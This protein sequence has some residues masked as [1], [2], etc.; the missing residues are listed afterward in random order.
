MADPWLHIIEDSESEKKWQFS[1]RR[2][3]RESAKE[4]VL[5]GFYVHVTKSVVP[6]PGEMKG[7]V[8]DN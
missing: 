2:T 7:K 8:F 6:P 1:L 5:S 3:L 4:L